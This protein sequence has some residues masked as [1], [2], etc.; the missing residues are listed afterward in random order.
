M[1]KGKR[2]RLFSQGIISTLLY[3]IFVNPSIRGVEMATL[4]NLFI[5]DIIFNSFYGLFEQKK[6]LLWL[7]FSFQIFYWAT[8]AIWLLVYNSF[9]FFSF[10]GLMTQWFI[11][12]MSVLIPIMVIEGLIGG[13]T[14]YKI[15]GRVKHLV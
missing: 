12:I 2:W 6:R 7:T 14:G 9:F 15:Y 11:P 5:C 10:E 13:Y 8:H 1:Y 3:L 4:T